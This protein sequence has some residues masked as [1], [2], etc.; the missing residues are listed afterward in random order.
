MWLITIKLK[1]FKRF[2]DFRAEFSQGINVVKGPLNEMG[3]ST[4]L[5]GIVAA[6]FYNPKSASKEI[7]GYVS[8]GVNKR[9][10]T[11]LEFEHEGNVYLLEKN[12]DKGTARLVGR[13]SGEE[14]DIFKEISVKMADLVGTDSDKLFSFTSCI[15]QD[16]VS[17]VSSGKKEISA[18][19]EE[20]VT[21]GAESTLASQVI[22]KLDNKIAAVRKGLDR[23]VKN[24]GVLANLESIIAN[25]SQRFN[26]V[27]S[28]V[29]MV[30]AEKIE[31]VA[32]NKR[33]AQVKGEFENSMVLLE[34]NKLRK[35]IEAS[36]ENIK[37]K[38]NE[39]ETMLGGINILTTKSR[40]ASEALS[41]EGELES[42]QRVSELSKSL[43]EI[44]TR[45]DTMTEDMTQRRE[46]MID[47][48]NIIEEL[49]AKIRQVELGLRSIDGI[50]SG[51]QLAEF[52]TRLD[53]IQIRREDVKR[54]LL[55]REEELNEAKAK[56]QG[57]KLVRILDAREY[58]ILAAVVTAGGIA[59]IAI[60]SLYFLVL[61]IL[62]I[63]LLGAAMW[64]RTSLSRERSGLFFLA[65]RVHDMEESLE[66]FDYV[67]R[68]MLAEVK[69]STIDEFN[70]KERDFHYWVEEK[71]RL[72]NQLEIGLGKA[73]VQEGRIQI[74]E[75]SLE[76]LDN[77]EKALLAEVNC[78]TVEDFKQ[79][80]KA[81]YRW[82]EE[83]GRYDNQLT[84]KL[85]GK[86]VEEI[87]QQRLEIIR[88]LRVAEDRLTEDL[89]ATRLSPEKYVELESKVRTLQQRQLEIEDR[90][91]RC[92]VVIERA[93]FDAE[94]QVKLE[95]ELENAQ[96]AL[97]REEKK[98][99]V[100]ELARELLS[101]ARAEMFLSANEA[102][103]QEIQK[104]FSIFT[105]GKYKQVMG[106][107]DLDF[108]V[109]SDEKGDWA[110]P[111]E[112][113]GGVIDEFYLASRLA[114]VKLIFRD[115]KPPLILDDPFVNF[116]PV[117][118]NRTLDFLQELSADYQIIIF[119]L[120][121]LYDK[122]ADNIILLND[123][124][125]LL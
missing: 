66:R 24:P 17:E 47:V 20:V 2:I 13:N 32:L 71:R 39:V 109:Y 16:Q 83:K 110:R 35:E 80:E 85:G 44:R 117:R 53:A 55:K 91:K 113:S 51:Q 74:A 78:N 63:G 122:V 31:L 72:E 111:E 48:W 30:E 107:D 89:V 68:D 23:P 62:G 79:K 69:C 99:K 58:I 97:R 67:E 33:L 9:Y 87:E 4:L 105:N 94:D 46:E 108:L 41:S 49:K 3:K 52:K 19:M 37:L 123:K 6:L 56:L 40:E 90:K 57:K 92:E 10:E 116:D 45:R 60:N 93:R 27:K 11:S 8:W 75:S 22:Q 59:G 70:S 114:L 50:E 18:S 103:E 118:L 120:S 98:L 77:Q 5:E 81:F 119:T 65:E 88:N 124:E 38:Y 125:R 112:L 76:E 26:E 36:I 21:G 64:G 29:A 25:L 14:L 82:M 54:D 106:R 12:F 15:R 86:P 1:N 42:E 73:S 121:D 115:K 100:Y 95:E 43:D 101:K 104:Y 84:G 61:V 96:E 7:E 34:K 28:E 102:L